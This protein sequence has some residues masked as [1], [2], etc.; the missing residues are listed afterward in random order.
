M[1]KKPIKKSNKHTSQTKSWQLGALTSQS[2][3]DI[4][5]WRFWIKNTQEDQH[6]FKL[7]KTKCTN[8]Q[9]S[10]LFGSYVQHKN[11]QTINW[12]HW[13]QSCA[14]FFPLASKHPTG[15]REVNWL[16]I[17]VLYIAPKK[18]TSLKIY[19]F[20]LVQLK[21]VPFNLLCVLNLFSECW[22]STLFQIL[23]G[24]FWWFW[25]IWK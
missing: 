19:L 5:L 7:D 3:Q 2:S 6:F 17:I 12:R 20:C 10:P 1:K 11:A 9:G 22:Q 23:S 8:F 18:R 16:S 25:F 24:C 13:S 15:K 21:S 4:Q 14:L